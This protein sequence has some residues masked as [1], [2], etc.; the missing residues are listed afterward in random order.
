MTKTKVV[1][2][3]E[4]ATLIR[5]VRSPSTDNNISADLR[6]AHRKAFLPVAGGN[7]RET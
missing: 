5:D 6:D 4:T 7:D 1:V 2:N 3:E